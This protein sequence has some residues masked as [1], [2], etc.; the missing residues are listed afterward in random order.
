MSNEERV[1]KIINEHLGVTIV[2][3]EQTIDDLGADS[4]DGVGLTMAIEEEF[5][6]NITDDEFMD[7]PT[8]QNIIT[9]VETKLEAKDGE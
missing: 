2:N 4:L 6:I 9:L 8:V 7:A 3:N 5:S 1:H